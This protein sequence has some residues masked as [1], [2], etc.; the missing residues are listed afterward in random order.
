MIYGMDQNLQNIKCNVT[1]QAP[2]IL[3]LHAT[4]KS[5]DHDYIFR[6]VVLILPIDTT[7]VF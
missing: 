7:D 4:Y 2:P 3:D 1:I 5:S 6:F